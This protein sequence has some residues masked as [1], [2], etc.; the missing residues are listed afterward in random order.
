MTASRRVLFCLAPERS[1]YNAALIAADHLREHGHCVVFAGADVPELASHARRQGIEHLGVTPNPR[2]YTERF[3]EARSGLGRLAV[4]RELQGALV[5]AWEAFARSGDLGFDLA[6]CD[7]I[8][9]MPA[10]LA[11]S[12]LRIPTLVLHSAYASRFSSRCPPVFSRAVA[13]EEHP[14]W[15]QRLAFLLEWSRVPIMRNVQV[16]KPASWLKA[17]PRLLAERTFPV[18]RARARAERNGWRFCYSEWGARYAAPEVVIGHRALDWHVLQASEQRC[19]LASSLEQR[20]DGAQDWRSGLDLTR[21]L[22][23]CNTSTLLPDSGERVRAATRGAGRIVAGMPRYLDAVIGAFHER[24]ARQLLVACG[25]F[26]DT[27]ASA[28]LPAHIRLL[29]SVPQ[30]EVLRHADLVITPGGPGTVR[31]CVAAGVP[32]LTFPIGTDQFGN[33]ARVQHFGA[34]LD[35]GDFRDVTQERVARL[36]ERALGDAALRNSVA[37]IKARVV[38]RETEWLM[39]RAFVQRHTGVAL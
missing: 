11:L 39:L 13:P 2:G 8:A 26:A 19:Y 34:G 28:S 30:L 16:R 5:G 33:A 4:Q 32:M 20:A 27:Y 31:E 24:P 18:A 7:G 23:Y 14:S 6:L 22:V 37:E 25:G 17:P 29:R 1:G 10:A 35:G 9:M 21:T 12:E 36:V 3:A 38:D 15:S